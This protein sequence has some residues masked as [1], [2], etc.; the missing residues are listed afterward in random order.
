MLYQIC[1]IPVLQN[2]V[3]SSREEALNCSKGC[4][5]IVQNEET[6]LIYNADFDPDLMVYDSSY[7]NEQAH[8]AVF[9]KHLDEVADKL[10][11]HFQTKPIIEI[12]CGKAFF[13]EN[14]QQM[15]FNIR[16]CDP[17]YTGDNPGVIKEYFS[18]ELGLSAPCIVL[19]HVLEHIYNPVAF[20]Q[21]IKEA[22]G[23]HGKVYIEVPC[24]QWIVDHKAC[25]DL[26]YEHVNYF[27]LDD[28]HR[29]FSVIHESG[30]IFGGQ[31]I[32]LIADLASIQVP[33][34]PEEYKFKFQDDFHHSLKKFKEQAGDHPAVIWGA[35]SK[36]V[37]FSILMGRLGFD[38]K[39]AIDINPNKQAKF[40][41]VS[42]LEVKAPNEAIE[43]LEADTYVFVMNSNYL[44]EI[45]ALSK[46]RYTYVCVDI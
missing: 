33:Q 31:Y 5:S 25:F 3:Y 15:G 22:N 39:F 37:L 24:L 12:G 44:E 4:L 17:T 2:R 21:G 16:G 19:R 45:K 30:H 11:N 26:F 8:S 23:G 36:G 35:A 38:F 43:H 40:L 18:K 42:G 27:L 14:L 13:L 46:N 32:Y 1:D 6:G 7:D 29:M 28:F 9:Q 41:P 20:L 34:R 10:R